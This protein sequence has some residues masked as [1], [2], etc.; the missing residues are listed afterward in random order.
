MKWTICILVCITVA[1]IKQYNSKKK[2]LNSIKKKKENNLSRRKLMAKICSNILEN[3]YKTKAST[4]ILN[5]NTI[6]SIA[7]HILSIITVELIWFFLFFL[8]LVPTQPKSIL[9]ISD[10]QSIRTHTLSKRFCK[11]FCDFGL[12]V[13]RLSR[14]QHPTTHKEKTTPLRRWLRKS[15][16]TPR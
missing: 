10:G 1:L 16:S 15:A 7:S 6:A 13:M 14:H 3:K 8:S 9:L 5:Q 12:H 2:S 11:T 4:L